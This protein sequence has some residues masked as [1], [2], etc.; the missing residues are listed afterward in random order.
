MHREMADE[1]EGEDSEAEG[2]L[3]RVQ[4]RKPFDRMSDNT[5]DIG[6][7]QWRTEGG[8]LN[9]T[10]NPTSEIPKFWQSRTGLQIERKMFS[11]HIQTY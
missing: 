10:L 4:I 9:P 3:V 7:R 5:S 1:W 8:G 11:V 6:L 2:R